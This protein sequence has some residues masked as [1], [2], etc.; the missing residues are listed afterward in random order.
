LYSAI[1]EFEWRADR[2][3]VILVGDA[4]PHPLPR[5]K[6][7]KEQVF[8]DAEKADIILHTVILPQ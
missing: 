5:G 8:R 4:P 1:H 2:K 6:V 3:T 7:T